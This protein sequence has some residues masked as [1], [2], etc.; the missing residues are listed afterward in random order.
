MHAVG[1][2]KHHL[3]GGKRQIRRI[4]VGQEEVKYV[5]ITIAQVIFI[6]IDKKKRQLVGSFFS[7]MCG[8]TRTTIS[9]SLTHCVATDEVVSD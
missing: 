2:T 4:Q 8:S 1:F 7:I 6:V 9:Y 5:R 3:N